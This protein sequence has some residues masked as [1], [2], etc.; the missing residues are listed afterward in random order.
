MSSSNKTGIGLNLWL[1][2]D[3]PKREDFC[4][5]N[6]IIDKQITDHKKDMSCHVSEE[7]RN[8]WNTN[9][10]CDIYY[11]DNESMRD[12]DTGCPF[13]PSAVIIFPSGV[14]PHV[15]D[16]SNGRGYIYT[17]Y[18]ST[19]GTTNGLLFR[20]DRK[21]LRVYQNLKG[22]KDEVVCLNETGVPYCYVCIR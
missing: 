3:K 14:T 2:G 9:I 4:N 22:V 6:I 11:G 21:T 18:G 10:F 8:K 16:A 13:N 19:F 1:G 12:I 15:W 7:E 17:A 20:N 5:D